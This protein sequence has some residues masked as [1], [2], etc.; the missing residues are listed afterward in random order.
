LGLS[1]SLIPYSLRHRLGQ[2]LLARGVPDAIAAEI[3]G[4]SPAILAKHYS[5]LGQRARE[6]KTHL[7]TVRGS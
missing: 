6:L 5:H 2:D 4:H 7:A 3:L 1:K